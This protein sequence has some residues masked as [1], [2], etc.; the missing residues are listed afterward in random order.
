MERIEAL[1]VYKRVLGADPT[2]ALKLKKILQLDWPTDLE[3]Y[4]S[5]CLPDRSFGRMVR[6]HSPKAMYSE[7]TE[8]VPGYDAIKQGFLCIA[9]AGDGSQ[10]AYHVPSG[11]IHLLDTHVYETEERTL[12]C[13]YEKWDCLADF[14]EYYI[15]QLKEL[16]S[17]Q[18]VLERFYDWRTR[19]FKRI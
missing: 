13:S 18:S 19:T 16:H 1:D 2:P 8:Y 17:K 4:V 12:K 11:Q 5:T 14:L 7:N 10:Y 15:S 9:G 3:E 6:F